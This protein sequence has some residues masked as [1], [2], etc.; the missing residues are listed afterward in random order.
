MENIIIFKIELGNESIGFA[1]AS[2]FISKM[3]KGENIS[4]QEVHGISTLRYNGKT[5]DYRT[6]AEYTAQ[7][8]ARFKS[9]LKPE[10]LSVSSEYQIYYCLW[11]E[12]ESLKDI[13]D[14]QYDCLIK[15][16]FKEDSA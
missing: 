9:I 12:N 10:N 15:K 3:N 8:K 5:D 7:N 1:K 11:I 16:F 14:L 6:I 4:L 2:N 13:V